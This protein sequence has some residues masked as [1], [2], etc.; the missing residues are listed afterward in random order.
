[1]S[2]LAA[3]IG[4]SKRKIL[5]NINKLKSIGLVERIGPAEGG[6]WKISQNT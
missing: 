3:Q 1:M 5:D 4:M 2:E 6:Y